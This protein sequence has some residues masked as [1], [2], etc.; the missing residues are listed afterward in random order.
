MDRTASSARSISYRHVNPADISPVPPAA[1]TQSAF[2]L[3][4][5]FVG[6]DIDATTFQVDASL[7]PSFSIRA[8]FTIIALG[9]IA[10]AAL[11]AVPAPIGSNLASHR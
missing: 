10:G 3:F 6:T 5:I 7:A 8:A 9:S 4:L 11:V 1:Q 2:D